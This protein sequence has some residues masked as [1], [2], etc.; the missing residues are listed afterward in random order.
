MP[1]EDRDSRTGHFLP[2]NKASVDHAG[3]A[4]AAE[5]RRALVEAVTAKD[6]KDVMGAMIA[7][8][9]DGNVFAANL[10]LD[11]AI[12]KVVPAAPEDAQDMSALLKQCWEEWAAPRPE[13][14]GPVEDATFSVKPNEPTE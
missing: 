2:G 8:A 9:K 5:L 13:R 14:A 12:G 1:T 3:R 6:I 11:R 7:E 10:V 4:R